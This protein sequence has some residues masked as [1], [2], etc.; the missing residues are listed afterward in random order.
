[1]LNTPKITHTVPQLTAVIHFTIPRD[2]VRHAMGPGIREVLTTVAA[3]G[4]VPVGPWFT[5]HLSMGPETFDFELGVPVT[6]PVKATGRVTIGEL[7][8]ATVARA[9]FR[10]D[11][12][13]LGAAWDKFDAWIAAHGHTPGP[14][15][16]ERYITGPESSLDPSKWRTELNRPLAGLGV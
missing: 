8:A 7:P 5:H 14:E 12:E 11:Y 3:Q 1:M 15:L 10:G 2:E 9:V 16:W 6:A 13:G 4:I